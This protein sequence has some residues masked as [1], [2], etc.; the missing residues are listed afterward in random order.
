VTFIDSTPGDGDVRAPSG[1]VTGVHWPEAAVQPRRRRETS[2]SL[3]V[4]PPRSPPPICPGPAIGGRT[5]EDFW[6]EGSK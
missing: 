4:D 6:G 1:P 3:G 5:G 2:G